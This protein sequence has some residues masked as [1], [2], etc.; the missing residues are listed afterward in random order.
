M[1]DVVPG[2][3]PEDEQTWE[4]AKRDLAEAEEL[5]LTRTPSAAVHKS[6][7]AMHHAARAVLLR[8]DGENAATKHGAV[9]GR[10]GF[11][12]KNEPKGST[13]LMQAGRDLNRVTRIE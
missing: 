1:S 10:F 11:I 13:E 5:D 3:G 9:I 8:R 2:R 7:Y 12:A 4:K 6:Y